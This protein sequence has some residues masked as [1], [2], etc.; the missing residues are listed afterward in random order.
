[1]AA[2]RCHLSCDDDRDD[3]HSVLQAGPLWPCVD[4]DLDQYVHTS[5]SDDQAQSVFQHVVSI[6]YLGMSVA[7]VREKGKIRFE[8]AVV[9]ALAPTSVRLTRRPPL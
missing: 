7:I 3:F 2:G 5:P 4:P 8:S 9:S 6:E 1:M